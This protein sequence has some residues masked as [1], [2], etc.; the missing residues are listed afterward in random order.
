MGKGGGG[1]GVHEGA[2]PSQKWTRPMGHV[3]TMGARLPNTDLGTIAKV[4]GPGAYAVSG[5][6][7]QQ[8]GVKRG[9]SNAR[10]GKESRMGIS[11][12]G[13][14]SNPGP[15]HYRNKSALGR[16]A[17]SRLRSSPASSLSSR[18]KL[19]VKPADTM[20]PGVCR[21]DSFLRPSTSPNK[22]WAPSFSFGGKH[23]AKSAERNNPGPGAYE[24]AAKSSV[25]RQISSTSASAPAFSLSSRQEGG[26]PKPDTCFPCREDSFTKI[27]KCARAR[28]RARRLLSPRSRARSRGLARTRRYSPEKGFSFG[29]RYAADPAKD[30]PGPG[31]YGEIHFSSRNA[32]TAL[33]SPPQ[34]SFGKDRRPDPTD[35]AGGGA[36]GGPGAYELPRSCVPQPDSM[37]ASSPNYSFG[38]TPSTLKAHQAKETVKADAAEPLSSPGPGHYQVPTTL[39]RVRSSVS[40][41][42]APAPSLAGR[43]RFGGTDNVDTKG[44]GPG[45]AAFV[46]PTKG[47]SERI[48][49]SSCSK[50]RAHAAPRRVS[51]ARPLASRARAG[52]LRAFVPAPRA[53]ARSLLLLQ[54]RFGSA[55]RQ[56]LSDG[57]KR[58]PGPGAYAHER[59]GTVKH[60]AP[61][62]SM[63]TKLVRKSNSSEA[64]GPGRCREDS[65]MGAQKS[66]TQWSKPSYSFGSRTKVAGLHSVNADNPGPG[67][68]G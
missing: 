21:E 7:G 19:S 33:E 25:Q 15:G 18:Q 4:P 50:A 54:V 22:A 27:S 47:P 67:A 45:P 46:L 31:T 55:R 57:D 11:T 26:K 16:Q 6:I 29:S 64:M 2:G 61:K 5:G 37:R 20:G 36:G 63:G 56:E 1:V 58:N 68:Y 65:S 40:V 10:F 23:Y 59:F 32:T 66:S 62:F 13:S 24:N 34:W 48:N 8:A 43:E 44:A 51:R 30:N 28:A 49:Q 17:D 60:A 41:H 35:G 38:F 9:V 39:G 12:S 14:L 52:L 3:K 53:H 42:T